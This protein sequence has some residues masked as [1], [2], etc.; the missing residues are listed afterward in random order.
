MSDTTRMVIH[1]KNG[2]S[3][4][5][6]LA[7]SSASNYGRFLD[8]CRAQGFAAMFATLKDAEGSILC[9]NPFEVRS[10]AFVEVDY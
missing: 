6:L 1:Y 5:D 4:E 10:I 7:G 3:T 9:I 8:Q 2:A